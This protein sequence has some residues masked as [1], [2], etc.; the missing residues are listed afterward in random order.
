MEIID[1][2]LSSIIVGEQDL[3]EV[4]EDDSIIEL[5]QDMAAK[6]LL[7]PVG[8]QGRPKGKYQLLWGGRRLAAAKRLKWKTI[9]AHLWPVTSAPIKAVA[10][11]ENLQRRDLTLAEQVEV[12]RYLGEK[13]GK[14]IEEIAAY[15][16]KGRSW[17]LD[18]VMIPNLQPDM[19]DALLEGAV[20]LKHIQEISR[21]G[22]EGTRSLALSH[23]ISAR[24]SAHHAKLIVQQFYSNPHVAD[25][26]KVGEKVA[27]GEIKVPVATKACEACHEVVPINEIMFVGVCKNGCRPEPL[28]DRPNEKD[29]PVSG[30][31]C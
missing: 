15:I 4:T 26:I 12:V 30:G 29:P 14:S 5:A 19:R 18:R 13:E 22:D 23:I 11:V 24:A 31:G 20:S 10:L 2:A 27:S 3:R 8:V 16:S 1:A 9:A 25:A 6:G 28:T 17:V 7:Q 21:L